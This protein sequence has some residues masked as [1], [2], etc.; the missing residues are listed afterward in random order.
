LGVVGA[1]VKVAI[2]HAHELLEQSEAVLAPENL[3]LLYGG[4]VVIKAIHECGH[5]ISC[6]YFGG[7]V[8]R[9]GVA[10]MYFSPMPF[11][12]A[13]ASWAFASKWQRIFVAAGGMIAEVFVAALATFVWAGTG[14]GTLHSLAYNMIFVASVTTVL[15]NANPLLRYDGYYILSD[16]LEMPNLQGRSMQMLTHLAER[17]LFGCRTSKNPAQTRNETALLAIYGIASWCY[18]AVVFVSIAL[19]MSTRY[20]LLGVLIAL[21][22][23]YSFTAKPLWLLGRYLSASP[24]IERT[25]RRAVL[26]TCG[27][28]AVI[29]ALLALVPIPNRFRAPGVLQAEEYSEIFTDVP[30]SLREVLAASGTQ[31][32]RGQPLLR[33]ESR[34]LDLELNAARAELAGVE[35][36]EARALDRNAGAINPIR[37][38][39]AVTE[40]RLRRIEGQQRNLLVMAPHA[41]T[42]IAP[43]SE[44]RIGQWLPRGQLV[45]RLVQD[46]GFR[47]TAVISQDDAANL[48]TGAAEGSQ[49]RILGQVSSALRVKAIRVTP[50]QQ[51]TL[52]SAALG[53]A[54]GG[55]IAV[56]QRDPSGA[57]AAEPFFELR[58]S[59]E[60]A[61][62]VHLLHGRSG[63]IRVAVAREPLLAQWWRKLRQ[64]LQKKYQI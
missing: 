48:F 8:H 20:L 63:W 6:R 7:E 23:I 18:R 5:A 50:A 51:E 36:E 33:F 10:L 54:G 16:W 32:T 42:W 29:L 40:K 9:M 56:S 14:S 58:A 35:A 2:D 1:A 45:G 3:L 13:S 22:C 12:D 38:R 17:Y 31:V 41:G 4:L 24:R 64:L 57:H 62:G 46:G 30:G 21:A 19:F 25:R 27:V 52:P 49:V 11:V 55:E 34:E 59:L 26:V 44:D 28:T 60:P 61:T 43:R 47:F 39:H 15:F 37:T 53:W